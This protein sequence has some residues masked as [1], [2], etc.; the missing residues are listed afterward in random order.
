MACIEVTRGTA[1]GLSMSQAAISIGVAVF[2]PS[3]HGGHYVP[4]RFTS[5]TN[6]ETGSASF[7]LHPYYM[8]VRLSLLLLA[9]SFA[10]LIFSFNTHSLQEQG[11]LH[12]DYTSDAM[13]QVF[14]VFILFYLYSF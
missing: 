4:V 8:D 3:I 10:A 9:A 13:E 14:F 11:I 12:A 1:Y 2:F 5:S 7:E 6:N